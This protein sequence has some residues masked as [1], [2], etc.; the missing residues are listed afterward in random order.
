MVDLEVLL[1]LPQDRAIVSTKGHCRLVSKVD[2]G[3]YEELVPLAEAHLLVAEFFDDRRQLQL[4]AIDYATN[5]PIEFDNRGLSQSRRRRLQQL[6]DAPRVPIVGEFDSN[7][8]G[9]VLGRRITR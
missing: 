1:V 3:I 7:R 9:F 2:G 8:R 6:L 4:E 5:A